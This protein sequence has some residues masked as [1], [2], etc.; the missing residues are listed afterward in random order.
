VPGF[1]G[2]DYECIYGY[3]YDPSSCYPGEYPLAY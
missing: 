2:N 1:Y 3:P